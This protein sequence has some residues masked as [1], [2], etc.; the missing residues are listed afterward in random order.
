MSRNDIVKQ[1]GSIDWDYINDNLASSMALNVKTFGAKGDGVTDD[2]NAFKKAI[3][4]GNNIYVP[5][6]TYRVKNIEI[7]NKS[8]FIISGDNATLKICDDAVTWIGILDLK[9]SSNVVVKGLIFDGNKE[10]VAGG[11]ISGCPA[12]YVKNINNIL[13]AD[14]RFE[15][16]NSGAFVFYGCNYVEAR[17]NKFFEGDCS[18]IFMGDVSSYINIH[19]NIFRGGTSEGISLHIDNGVTGIKQYHHDVCIHDNIFESKSNEGNSIL[20]RNA[21]NV[22]IQNNE[23]TNPF[24]LH[25]N[26]IIISTDMSDGSVLTPNNIKITS[27]LFNN[28]YYNA[29]SIDKGSYDIQIENNVIKNNISSIANLNG[30]NIMVKNN[31]IIDYTTSTSTNML[32]LGNSNICLE[33][34]IFDLTNVHIGLLTVIL[35][36]PSLKNI[37]IL[38]NSIIQANTCTVTSL[39]IIYGDGTATSLIKGNTGFANSL[40]QSNIWSGDSVICYDDIDQ[41]ITSVTTS[42]DFGI[43]SMWHKNFLLNN[44]TTNVY[45]IIDMGKFGS[46]YYGN[47]ITIVAGTSD[48]I[49]IKNT[50][51]YL[52]KTARTLTLNETV[53]FIYINDKYYEI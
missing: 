39:K 30:I 7:A 13:I 4:S 51:T 10:N 53:S 5:F 16:S 27:N 36:N 1:N 42:A 19:N 41:K 17:S 15:N 2:S 45:N 33:G 48:N 46:N 18:L 29:I 3:R 22:F 31:I 12:G 25:N 35:V 6:G 28:I 14:C 37:K 8:Q 11:T 50:A 49:A 21:Y 44:S 9:N 47:K 34:N 24:N 20:V 40:I 32:N 43:S 38:N 26:G 23:F 52:V